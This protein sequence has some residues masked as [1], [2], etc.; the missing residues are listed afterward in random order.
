MKDTYSA[1]ARCR[2]CNKE[3]IIEIP[4]GIP[5]TQYEKQI[6]CSYCGCDC[7]ISPLRD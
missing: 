5:M 1:R 3:E 7:I 4:F 2:N 6:K